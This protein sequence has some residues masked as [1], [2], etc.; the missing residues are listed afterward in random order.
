M[1]KRRCTRSR[2]WS[3]TTAAITT[4]ATGSQGDA[5]KLVV[6]GNVRDIG[7]NGMFL[8]TSEYVPVNSIVSITIQF[9]PRCK[10]STLPLN[11]RGKV[12][13]SNRNGVGIRFTSIDL[14][15]LQRIIVEKMNRQDRAVSQDGP[16]RQRRAS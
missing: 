5:D 9:D 1:N 12:V 6:K 11:A 2:V 10:S 7:S 15:L 14:S 4:E 8:K 13:H 16:P 3:D